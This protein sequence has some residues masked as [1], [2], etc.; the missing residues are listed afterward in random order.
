M[1][2]TIQLPAAFQIISCVS[3]PAQAQPPKVRANSSSPNKDALQQEDHPLKLRVKELMKQRCRGPRVLPT[4]MKVC[5][6]VSLS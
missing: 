2:D 1:L 6:T 5:N 4:N 3:S